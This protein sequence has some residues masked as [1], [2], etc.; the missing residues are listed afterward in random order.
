M[1][2]QPPSPIPLAGTPEAAVLALALGELLPDPP[3]AAAGQDGKVRQVRGAKAPGGV[4]PVGTVPQQAVGG[5]RI[6]LEQG[7]LV[8]Q[9][10][11]QGTRG[12]D[13]LPEQLRGSDAGARLL[14]TAQLLQALAVLGQL[15]REA[16][17]ASAPGRA[18]GSRSR[19][20][21]EQLH[22]FWLFGAGRRVWEGQG[23]PG[24]LSEIH[25]G[26]LKK[27][28][29]QTHQRGQPLEL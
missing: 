9:E 10:E 5:L 29:F 26:S 16:V 27:S 1:S 14:P 21:A 23:Q 17:S 2:L 18:A 22:L 6:Q 12:Q 11:P 3:A 8:E 24:H 15:G 25:H 4:A 19:H 28:S 7:L 20:L 13:E